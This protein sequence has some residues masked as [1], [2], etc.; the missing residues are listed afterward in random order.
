MSIEVKKSRFQK[1]KD[2]DK[3][4]AGPSLQQRSR[5]VELQ[6]WYSRRQPKLQQQ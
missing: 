5:R 4:E 3:C 1:I 6:G 2:P